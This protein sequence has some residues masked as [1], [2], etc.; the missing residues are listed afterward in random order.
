MRL[1]K[2]SKVASLDFNFIT[3]TSTVKHVL[4]CLQPLKVE[5]PRCG[6]VTCLQQS[7]FVDLGCAWLRQSQLHHVRERTLLQ[8]VAVQ[9]EELLELTPRLRVLGGTKT[10]ACYNNKKLMEVQLQT[11]PSPY[12]VTGHISMKEKGCPPHLQ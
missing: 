3:R 11:S 2:S 8:V 6:P 5:L 7:L 4:A 12:V 10:R 9:R 1:Q